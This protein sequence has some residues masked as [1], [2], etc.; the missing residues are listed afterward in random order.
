MGYSI[1]YKVSNIPPCIFATLNSFSR[2]AF[3]VT[4][5]GEW[6]NALND[7]GLFMRGTTLTATFAD[8]TP[9][10]DSS[11]W[12]PG[13]K[14]G[15]MRFAMASMDAFGDWFFWTWKVSARQMRLTLLIM[16]YV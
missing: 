12:S 8:C 5:A 10:T 14:A 9:W 11:T 2:T 13:T 15:L 4:I 16:I 3:G 7:C 6:S 1:Q